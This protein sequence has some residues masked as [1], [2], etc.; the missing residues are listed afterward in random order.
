M[1][2]GEGTGENSISNVASRDPFNEYRLWKQDQ[3]LDGGGGDDDN[4]SSEYNSYDESEFEKYC[5]ANSLMGGTSSMCSSLGTCNDF[6][7]SDFGSFKNLKFDDV[8][9]ARFRRN[10]GDIDVANGISIDEGRA[11]LRNNGSQCLPKLKVKNVMD[12]R[13]ILDTGTS[14]GKDFYD[15]DGGDGLAYSGSD[16]FET[17]ANDYSKVEEVAGVEENGA[18]SHSSPRSSNSSLNLAACEED[19]TEKSDCNIGPFDR[20]ASVSDNLVDGREA[21]RGPDE[22]EGTSSKGE[23]SDDDG[24]MFGYGTD[25]ENAVDLYESRKLQYS[26]AA[27]ID[28]R[29]PLLMNSSV[30][31]GSEDWDDFEQETEDGLVS[32]LWDKPQDQQNEQLEIN[33][34]LENLNLLSKDGDLSFIGSV[35]KGSARDISGNSGQIHGTGE[36]I[37]NQ[38][39]YSIGDVTVDKCPSVL[40]KQSNMNLSNSLRAAE[41]DFHCA[42]NEKVSGLDEDEMS[43]NL[44]SGKPAVQLDSLSDITVNQLCSSSNEIPQGKERPFEDPMAKGLTALPENS[45][46]IDLKRLRKS[47]PGPLDLRNNH[48]TPIKVEHPRS[49]ESY[50]EIV[51]EMEEILLDSSESHR[52]RFVKGNKLSFSQQIQIRDGSSTASTSGTDDAYP[53]IQDP[54]KIEGVEVVGAKQKKGDVSLGER[55]VGVKEYTVYKL[56]VWSGNDQW[57]VERRYRDFYTLYRHLKRLF[58]DHGLTLPSPWSRVEQES[59]KIFG[60]ASPGVVSERTALI[61]ECLRSVLHSSSLYN[62]PTS[63][64]WFLSPQKADSSSSMLNALVP[65]PTS[66]FSKGAAAEDYTNLG[67]TISL[68]VK[69]QPPKSI[70]QLVE[71]QRNT[72]A[73]CHKHFNTGKTLMWEFVETLGWGK[74]RLCEYTGQLFCTS[75]HTNDTAVLPARVL[76][77]WDF[78]LYPVSQLAKSFLDSIYEQPMLCVSAVN[79]FLFSKVPTLLHIMGIRKKIGAMFPYLR[80]PFR[81][82]VH[83]GM[84]SRRYLLEGNDFF[85]L[86]DLV[87][88]S[89]GAFAVLPFMVETV[90]SKMLQHITQQCLICCDTGVPCGARQ[91][92][93][94]T[95]SL[96]FP[97]QESEV[98]RCASCESVFHKPCFKKLDGCLCGATSTKTTCSMDQLKFQT[99]MEMDRSRDATARAPDSDTPVGFLSSLFSRTTSDKIWGH[100][101]SRPIILMDS[102]PS[103]SL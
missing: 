100:K 37:E 19:C 21:E 98:D 13:R 95:S 6:L 89:K 35:Q 53:L 75:C 84:G 41:S 76:H 25:D 4:V 88:L 58:A 66:E 14:S 55:I 61:Q 45:Q 43:V 1:I 24:S 87:D 52:A 44:S 74:P 50:D 47:S 27:K 11:Q 33:K 102:L 73:G 63:L 40:N 49:D 3:I 39:N 15:K 38:E 42:S 94:D 20:L 22:E 97:F 60:N 62:T 99:N 86:R 70:K 72:C 28:N 23:H 10:S 85:A 9:G 30:A 71:A 78:T 17:F 93:E 103:T 56:R 46:G 67:K 32:S 26:Q 80:C 36:S 51:L 54:T 91:A 7:D 2:N 31:F 8:G 64:I 12:S 83:K 79:P 57:E 96:I 29:N 101:K 48:L 90:S 65:P 82:T 16:L 18:V 59:R 69:I 68:L 92:C 5:S 34:K 77:H 81:R